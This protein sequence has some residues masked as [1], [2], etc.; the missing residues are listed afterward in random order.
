MLEE[1][2]ARRTAKER[3][4]QKRLPAENE[5]PKKEIADPVAHG[6]IIGENPSMKTVIS[7]IELVAP[8]QASVLILGESGTGKEL[9]A[10]EIYRRSR[11]EER[12]FILVNCAA[13]SKD[14]FIARRAKDL[15]RPIPEPTK[16]NRMDLQHYDWRGNVRELQNAIERALIL[17]AGG[18]LHFD[19]PSAEKSSAV[20]LEQRSRQ[21]PF[22][23]P[24]P[25][26]SE[27]DIKAFQKRNIVAAAEQSREKI[28]GKKGAA[29]PPGVQPTP[30]TE[31]IKAMG[32]RKPVWQAR[33]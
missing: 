25:I 15:S 31:R 32:I 26:M 10:R 1:E 6:E 23:I 2:V 27:E 24:T 18:R 16:I 30:L 3:S 11:L 4:L 12:P 8:A 20:D 17:A 28:Y 19:L 5:L 14:L 33:E 22:G 21:T 29:K 7:Q 9:A 13:I